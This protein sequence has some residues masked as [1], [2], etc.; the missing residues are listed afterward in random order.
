MTTALRPSST[1]SPW[2][3]R[4]SPLHECTPLPSCHLRHRIPMRAIAFPL[5]PLNPTST[6]WR[7]VVLL[8]H[9]ASIS[10]K[11]ERSCTMPMRHHTQHPLPPPAELSGH[12]LQP[13][14]STSPALRARCFT[15]TRSNPTGLHNH[16]PSIA[17][18][19]QAALLQSTT[20]SHL[21]ES[22]GTLCTDPRRRRN[23]THNPI[24]AAS[25]HGELDQKRGSPPL[26]L[27][28]PN[29]PGTLRSRQ[30][31]PLHGTSR[32]MCILET[33]HLPQC[34][35]RG[36]S[37]LRPLHTMLTA[38]PPIP[39]LPNSIPFRPSKSLPE[40]VMALSTR[41][42]ATVLSSKSMQQLD[43][44]SIQLPLIR[45]SHNGRPTRCTSAR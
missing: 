18:A 41:W 37:R 42:R 31:K 34:P 11:S 4:P 35:H 20:T 25:S 44:T 15:L 2:Q 19:R 7:C 32:L 8:S 9:S 26:S 6:R 17:P 10:N 21:L 3:H 14:Q 36:P 23:T 13:P 40:Q 30:L 5:S 28:S 24:A 43:G 16:A 38:A 29:L 33:F 22:P 12:P 39:S 45:G 27:D 1:T